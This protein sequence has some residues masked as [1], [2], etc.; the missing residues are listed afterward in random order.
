[1][2]SGLC[3]WYPC[4]KKNVNFLGMTSL[5]RKQIGFTTQKNNNVFTSFDP[6]YGIYPD[7]YILEFYLI[8][9]HTYIYIYIQSY[10]YIYIYLH[11][12]KYIYIH[13]HI[14]IYIYMYIYI[15][16]YISIYIYIYVY[17]YIYI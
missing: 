3:T 13:I 4:S 5:I 1:M 15:Y 11:I 10:I 8:N 7:I 17:I 16:V 6:H 2:A 9:T 14:C 12:Y